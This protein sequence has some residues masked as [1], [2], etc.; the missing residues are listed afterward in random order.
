MGCV[1]EVIAGCDVSGC[2][3][4]VEEAS[5]GFLVVVNEDGLDGLSVEGV[6]GVACE[7]LLYMS[8]AEERDELSPVRFG[9]VYFEVRCRC[10]TI[11]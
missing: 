5:I 10:V 3:R 8:Y 9:I 4:V 2:E 11:V 7:D 1:E 6:V